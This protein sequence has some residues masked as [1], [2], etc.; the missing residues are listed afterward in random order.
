[1]EGIG[2]PT[3]LMVGVITSSSIDVT[4]DAPSGGDA[5][6]ITGY[7]LTWTPAD[8]GGSMMVSTDGSTPTTISGLNSNTEY[9]IRV[10]STS[11]SGNGDASDAVTGTTGN[12]QKAVTVLFLLPIHLLF[13]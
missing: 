8:G 9:S 13:S 1:M 12:V 11:S 5:V 3:G 7:V 10:T 2:A 4:W 6:A